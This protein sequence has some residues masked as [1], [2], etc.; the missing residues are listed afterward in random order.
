MAD[1]DGINTFYHG[2]AGPNFSG[3]RPDRGASDDAD[4][5]FLSRSP[6]VARRYGRVFSLQHDT[7]HLPRITVQDWWKGTIPDVTFIILGN[8]GYDFPVDTLILRHPPASSF[9]EVINPEGLDDGLAFTHHPL[10]PEARQFEVFIAD[11][12]DGDV[13]HWRRDHA[14]TLALPEP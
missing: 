4:M 5:L 13:D 6:N 9:Q 11:V 12:Y 1:V 3:W 8:S 2:S 14:P 10:F 7:R